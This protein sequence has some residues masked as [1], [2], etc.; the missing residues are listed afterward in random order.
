MYQVTKLSMA[1]AA[2][3]L[4]TFIFMGQ[5]IAETTDN[6]QGYGAESS[7]GGSSN[8]ASDINADVDIS[9][10]STAQNNS[11]QNSSTFD[12]NSSVNQS[13]N[14]EQNSTIDHNSNDMSPVTNGVSQKLDGNSETAMSLNKLLPSIK[15]STEN[16]PQAAQQVNA[17]TWS[18]GMAIGA[19]ADNRHNRSLPTKLQALLNWHHNG[20]GAVDGYWGKN[21]RKAMQAFQQARGLA[22]TETLNSET[23]QA[24]T[25]NNELMSQPVLVSY[26]LTDTDI[27]IKTTT[28]P[29]GAEAKAKLDV[30]GL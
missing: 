17:A 24:L 2:L 10:D 9:N 6:S 23:W 3:G 7:I 30:V 18:T 14:I 16:L 11:M 20:V 25:K 1:M 26:T 21:T 13:S 15:Y 4:S 19:N 29:A 5:V 22:V 27:N 28:I 8:N 12:Q